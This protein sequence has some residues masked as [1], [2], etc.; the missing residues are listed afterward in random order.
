M[1]VFAKKLRS[2]RV[3]GYTTVTHSYCI[4]YTCH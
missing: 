1:Y 4:H 2:D 3:Q